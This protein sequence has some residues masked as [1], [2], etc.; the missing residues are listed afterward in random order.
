MG[1]HSTAVERDFSIRKQVLQINLM[2]KTLYRETV[3]EEHD[4]VGVYV[5]EPWER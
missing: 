2:V 4:N 5:T 3:K 1:R